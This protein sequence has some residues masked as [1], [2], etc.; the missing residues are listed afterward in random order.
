MHYYFIKNASTNFGPLNFCAKFSKA[1]EFID[2]CK[3]VNQE[4]LKR[5]LYICQN[6]E[7]ERISVREWENYESG[8]DVI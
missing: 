6:W 8:L 1:P 4:A 5:G 2:I 7:A 3:A